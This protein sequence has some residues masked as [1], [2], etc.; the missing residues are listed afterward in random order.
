MSTADEIRKFTAEKIGLQLRLEL[1]EE[2]DLL[3]I[4]VEE[5]VRDPVGC[6]KRFFGERAIP[7]IREAAADAKA[8]GED[9]TN[10]L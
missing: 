8:I 6:M 10:A 4:D 7:L 9:L 1:L 3:Q 5:L 2:R